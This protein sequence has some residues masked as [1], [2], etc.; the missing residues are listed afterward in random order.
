ML[1]KK[2]PTGRGNRFE[3]V[4]QMP[5]YPG[6]MPA[7]MEFIGKNIKYPVAAQK[8]KIQGRVTIQFIVN[9]EATSSIPE[10]S[11]VPTLCWMPKQSPDYHYA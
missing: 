1:P 9:T 4:E 10:F 3:V 2:L 6:G 5:E 7:M 11:V 8:A